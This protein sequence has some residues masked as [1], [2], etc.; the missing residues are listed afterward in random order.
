MRQVTTTL[1]I[2]LWSLALTLSGCTP[3]EPKQP[4]EN[5]AFELKI[6]SV[7]KTSVDFS[8]TPDDASLT[9][10][11]MII[12]KAYFDNFE[13]DDAYVNDDLAWFEESALNEGV[14]LEEWLSER[15]MV[16]NKNATEEGLTPDTEYYLYAYHI[17]SYGEVISDLEKVLFSTEGYTMQ[18]GDF[19]VSVGKITYETATISVIPGD[20][21]MPYFVNVMSKDDYE[22][23]GGDQRAFVRHLEALRAYYI[24]FDQ[25]PAAMIANLC[26]KGPSSLPVDELTAG[27][28][29]YAYALGVDEEFFALT[30]ATVMEFTTASPTASSLTFR[31]DIQEVQ[32]DRVIGSIIPSNNDSYVCSIQLAEALTWFEKEEQLVRAITDDLEWRYGSVEAALHCGPTDLS[33]LVGLTPE[34]D[35]VIIC[36]GW[37]GAINTEMFTH[38][39]T[40]AKAAGNPE[41]FEVDFEVIRL[42][43]NDMSVRAIPSVGCYYFFSLIES[44]VLEDYTATMGDKNAAIIAFA[45]EEIDFGAEYFECSRAEYLTDLGAYIGQ[46]D[47]YFNQLT[48]NTEYVLYAVAVDLSSGE[49]TS[50]KASF[51]APIR[52]QEKI[53]GS[54]RVDF[55]ISKYYDGSELA[56]LD[57]TLFGS[58]RGKAVVPYEVLPSQSAVE[59][60][61]MF[62]SG[63]YTEWDCSDEDIY[64]QLVTFGYECGSEDV[65]LN[66]RGGVAVLPYDE[67]YTF[68]G[69]A[70]DTEGNFGAGTLYIFSASQSGTSPAE[71]FIATL[72]TPVIPAP[73]AA[74]VITRQPHKTAVERTRVEHTEVL[75]TRTNTDSHRVVGE[76]ESLH[77]KSLAIGK[78]HLL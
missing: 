78:R 38:K 70:K 45:N 56:A 47:V 58:C 39:F 69:I 50:S 14:T 40:T 57:E 24:G 62:S 7:T 53:V 20:S 10:I 44:R 68:L 1:F 71:E 4:E 33:R 48:P 11:A 17:N 73:A 30:E 54:A 66:S 29:Y 59:W 25:T 28:S 15:L 22:Y 2:I 42:G 49:I 37:N 75:K 63:D 52:T 35:Y 12:D 18:Q 19:E 67:V 41:E 76:S 31:A 72:D 64:V 60:Y 16:G 74:S 6:N 9:Y 3:E 23:F 34:T 43:Y 27:K 5:A 32:Y 61:T 65:S 13:S 21:S 26:F 77:H 46:S 36:F 51:S 8:I 55:N